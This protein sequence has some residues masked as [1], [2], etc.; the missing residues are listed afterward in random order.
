MYTIAY[1]LPEQKDPNESIKILFGVLGV[2]GTGLILAG[3]VRSF[4]GPP[5]PSY[6][7]EWYDK[8]KEIMKERNADPISGGWN[9]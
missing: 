8:T 2:F 7:K 3:V 5:S 6:T 4:A 9:K 1:D